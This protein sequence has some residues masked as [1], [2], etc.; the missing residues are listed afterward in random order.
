MTG[1][2]LAGGRNLRMGRDKAALPWQGAD[3]LHTILQRLSTVCSELIVVTNNPAPDIIDGVRYVSD[4]IPGCGPLSGIHAG[5][6]YASSPISFVIA[7]DMP[8][9]QPAAVS[10]LFSQAQGWDA[11]IPIE[12]TFTEPLFACY[13]K[14]CIPY[15]ELLLRQDIRKTQRLIQ[16]IRCKSISLNDLR[17][18]D[19]DLK[20]LR[21]IN[22]PTDY[23]A[24]LSEIG[25]PPVL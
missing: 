15:I 13:A 14:T 16:L 1:I 7:C 21:N 20:L 11:V 3:F 23:Q 19:P 22:S 10:W 25:Q 5:L 12:A 2:V 24:A 18:F 9:V 4:I 17:P 6:H 8:F